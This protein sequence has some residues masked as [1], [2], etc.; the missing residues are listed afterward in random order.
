MATP[1]GLL[2]RALEPGPSAP[3]AAPVPASVVT[4]PP[5]E[6]LRMR[7]LPVCATITL[8]LQSTAT[9]VGEEI[10]APAPVP[11]ANDCE[12]SPASVATTPPG[13]ILRTRWLL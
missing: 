4:A 10:A 13:E 7:L 2:N 5:G 11:S 8:P 12:P 1:L 3:P 6:I 9:P